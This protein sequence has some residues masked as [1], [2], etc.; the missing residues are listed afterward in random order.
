LRRVT[1][2]RRVLSA[3]VGL[4][5]SGHIYKR[6]FA[7]SIDGLR[8]VEALKHIGRH[9]KGCWILV[10]DRAPIHTA[11]VVA[12]Y[13][14]AHPEVIVEWLPPYAPELN[15][16]EYCHGNVKRHLKNAVPATREELRMMVN[17]GF[18]RL[19]HRPDLMLSFFHRA[20]LSVKQLWLL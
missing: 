19:R 9:I 11:G 6:Q 10:W 13:L 15:A 4:T 17:R 5:L 7:G 12:D 2:E 18:A 16:E 20:G 3:A 1:R 14:A 8:V